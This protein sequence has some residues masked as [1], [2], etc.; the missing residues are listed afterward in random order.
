MLKR[1][2]DFVDL[3]LTGAKPVDGKPV[4]F[5]EFKLFDTKAER[6]DGKAWINGWHSRTSGLPVVMANSSDQDERIPGLAKAKSIVV[7]PMPQEY[8][9]IAWTSPIAGT[10]TIAT[11]VSHAHPACGNGVAW[12]LEARRG[13]KATEIAGG[14]IALGKDAKHE[15][16]RAV[17]VGDQLI[18]A[19]DA[20]NAD[21]VCD[22]T[23][24]AFT[25]TETAKP[26]RIWDLA[27][28]IAGSIHAGNP[29]ADG[30]GNKAVWSFGKGPAR[31]VAPGALPIPP[32][33][34]LGRWKAAA[35]DATKRDELPKLAGELKKLLTGPRP[36]NAKDANRILYDNLATVD[37]QLLKGLDATPFRN[38]MAKKYGPSGEAFDS[39]GNL[40]LPA[41]GFVDLRLPA[42]LLAGRAFV[43]E[44]V[45]SAPAEGRA[46]LVQAATLPAD[47]PRWDGKSPLLV[48]PGGLVKLKSG[49][50]GFRDAF[51][52]YL[53]FPPVIPTDEVVSLK[54]FHREDEPL[55]RLFL[56]DAQ[57][58]ELDHL[59][60]EHQFVSKQYRLENE[61]LPQFIGFVTQD[62]PKAME[63]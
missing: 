19:V 30:H 28:D 2:I 36:A 8:V 31:A 14:G 25:I 16:T 54:M 4:P 32:D 53:C 24:V 7:H 37:G 42:S 17:Q 51:P 20:K 33:S 63:L 49:F 1:W 62:Q 41:N 55:R 52:I 11:T 61:H 50:D 13:Q 6:I 59:W 47:A 40:I 27:K 12:W 9:G 35:V 58:K 10:V 39:Q 29:H 57:A 44:A 5:A 23:G 60:A 45:L 18:L 38:P 48:G 22:L 46:V 56:N 3:D 34:I 21:H 43:A 15:L 26:G